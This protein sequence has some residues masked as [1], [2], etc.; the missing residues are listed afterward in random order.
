MFFLNKK[1][2]QFWQFGK[3][4]VILGKTPKNLR[5][6]HNKQKTSIKMYNY[7]KKCIIIHFKKLLI[8]G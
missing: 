2:P 3:I 8:F 4:L 5:I 1:Y 6:S 7:A